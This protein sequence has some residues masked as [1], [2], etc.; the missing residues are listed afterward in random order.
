M[1]CSAASRAG[2]SKS[3]EIEKGVNQ[4]HKPKRAS[5]MLNHNFIASGIWNEFRRIVPVYLI[6]QGP[7][8]ASLLS[9]TYAHSFDLAVYRLS[10]TSRK[11]DSI[12]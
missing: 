12:W 10:H 9:L 5:E 6:P 1:K 11:R 7:V 8:P 3:G 2:Y 4:G